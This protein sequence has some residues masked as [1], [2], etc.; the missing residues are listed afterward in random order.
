MGKQKTTEQFILDAQGIHS[1]KYDYSK[2]AYLKSSSKITIVCPV[3]GDCFSED[4]L[5]S[6]LELIHEDS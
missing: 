1:N 6:I 5:P 3:H 4:A 2:V